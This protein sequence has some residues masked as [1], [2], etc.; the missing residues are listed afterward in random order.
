MPGADSG[1]AFS[2]CEPLEKSRGFLHERR[3]RAVKFGI[4]RC[5][6]SLT[7]H[8]VDKA[9][10]S[11]PLFNQRWINALFRNDRRAQAQT[12]P[13]PVNLKDAIFSLVDIDDG[14][15]RKYLCV[16][17]QSPK[18]GYRIYRDILLGK[19]VKNRS[20]PFARHAEKKKA[21]SFSLE[22]ERRQ[23]C[24]SEP[25]PM[26]ATGSHACQD[27]TVQRRVVDN[28]YMPE[29]IDVSSMRRF[30]SIR[31]ELFE[32]ENDAV[33]RN[34]ADV[35]DRLVNPVKAEKNVDRAQIDLVL[36]IR[37]RNVQFAQR[38]PER[39]DNFGERRYF[40]CGRWNSTKQTSVTE[41]APFLRTVWRLS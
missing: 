13:N 29:R 27:G 5:R 3:F 40:T 22:L 12:V 1:R 24:V 11:R 38:S 19:A 17:L 8:S 21:L 10:V 16:P 20:T 33:I 37:N 31:H 9:D 26:D 23:R 28:P 4:R 34:G 18:I 25:K 30:G 6:E 7:V 36:P 15:G 35:F 41:V 14:L 2:A 39:A 32:I